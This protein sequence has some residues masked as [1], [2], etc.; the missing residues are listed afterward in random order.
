MV[1]DIE[2]PQPA[3]LPHRERDKAPQL[4]QLRLAE[5]PA[6]PV[7]EP[8]V[9]IQPPGDRLGVGERRLVAL[10]VLRGLLEVDEI[11]GL[12]LL[13]LAAEGLDGALVAAE[14]A[15]YRARNVE[16]AELLHRMVAHAGMEDVAPR[17][18]ERPE[19]AGDMSAHRGTLRT[20]RAFPRAP[21]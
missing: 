17:I 3:L 5:M 14:L 7:P 12:R 13:E 9:R 18:G 4:D 2:Q 8:V 21:L 20:R 11:V 10:T 1:V 15:G 6:Q 19:R 16:P